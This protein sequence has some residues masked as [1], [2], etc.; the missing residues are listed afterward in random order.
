MSDDPPRRTRAQA[1][2][3]GGLAVVAKYGPMYMAE[4]GRWGG[5][6]VSL[7]KAHMRAIGARGG[8]RARQREQGQ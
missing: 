1:A 2:R 6:M 3:L 7:D 8:R 5:R 4:L